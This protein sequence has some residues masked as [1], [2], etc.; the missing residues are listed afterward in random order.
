[1]AIANLYDK[2]NYSL[3]VEHLMFERV[4]SVCVCVCVCVFLFAVLGR[5]TEENERNS[6]CFT[7]FC[8]IKN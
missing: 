4:F 3:C 7:N 8:G 1:V 2:L 6:F 5:M